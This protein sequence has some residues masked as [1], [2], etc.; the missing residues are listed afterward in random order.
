MDL[1]ELLEKF[2]GQEHMEQP[3]RPIGQGSLTDL[4]EYVQRVFMEPYGSSLIVTILE[5]KAIL[6]VHNRYGGPHITFLLR[7]QHKALAEAV[8]DLFRDAAFHLEEKGGAK[9]IF[10]RL[11]D[12]WLE[13]QRLC[14]SSFQV[15]GSRKTRRCF[16]I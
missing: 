4:P 3:A 16:F 6:W 1:H 11:P 12:L 10:G 7:E 9:T 15:T 13:R 8:P 14:K 2:G 5:A